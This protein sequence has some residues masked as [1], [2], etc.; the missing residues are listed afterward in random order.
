MTET[1]LEEFAA[2]S[3]Y[4]EILLK[5]YLCGRMI[6]SDPVLHVVNGTTHQFDSQQCIEDLERYRIPYV[7]Q[8][9]SG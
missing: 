9:G 5:C 4:D 7:G 3:K 1:T 2:G 8:E 6:T